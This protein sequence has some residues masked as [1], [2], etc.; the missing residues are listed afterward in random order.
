VVV[1]EANTALGLLLEK[2]GLLTRVVEPEAELS[3]LQT[4]LAALVVLAS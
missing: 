2:T 4:E 1:T 3:L